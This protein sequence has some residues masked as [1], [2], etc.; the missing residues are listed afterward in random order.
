MA[1]IIRLVVTARN[2]T[3]AGF[4][5]VRNSVRRL[6]DD[7]NRGFRTMGGDASRAFGDAMRGGIGNGITTAFR[8][9][10]L[11]TIV[12]VTAIALATLFATAFAGA[13]AIGWGG[14]FV[15]MGIAFALQNKKIRARWGETLKDMGTKY[16]A[17]SRPM[18]QVV[19]HARKKFKDL[20]DSFA[21]HFG[22][23]MASAAPHVNKF[24]DSISSGIKKM[25]KKSFHPMMVAFEQLLDQFGP[26]FEQFMDELGQAFAA[27]AGAIIANKDAVAFALYAVLSIITLIINAVAISVATFGFLYDIVTNV[28][29]AIKEAWT[30]SLRMMKVA[31]H[32]TTVGLDIAIA[33]IQRAWNWTKRLVGKTIN[34]YQ[35]GLQAVVAWVSRAW[36]W[37]KRLIGKTINFYQRGLQ[38]IVSWINRAIASVRRLVGKTIRFAQRGL[39]TIVSWAQKAVSWINRIKS[40]TIHIGASVSGWIKKLFAKGG[41][42]GMYKGGVRGLGG[43]GRVG[44]AATG[45]VRNNMTMVGEHGPELVDLPV[46]SRVKSNPDTK[47]MMGKSGGGGGGGIIEIKSSGSRVDDML[48]E[49]LREAVR[50]R[51]GNVQLVIG[52]RRIA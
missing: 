51:G 40:K 7:M 9:P 13:V 35:N 47:R 6:G 43:G 37:V 17:M 32:F 28:A 42:V 48:I 25:G 26:K 38:G 44:A 30:W 45:G 24:M 2:N 52:G 16:K 22:N 11:A 8:N 5:A 34:F 21:G 19:E 14:L 46:G 20:G 4:R 41:V 39:Q 27:L 23:A 50:V 18:E 36:G 10:A 1:S 33:W 15:G 3:A 31:W 29:G 12:T 49:I